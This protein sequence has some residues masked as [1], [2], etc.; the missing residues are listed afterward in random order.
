[1]RAHGRDIIEIFGYAPDDYSDESAKW[2]TTEECPFVGGLCTKRSHENIVYG[3]CSLSA[4]VSNGEVIVCPK[5]LYAENYK[6]LREVVKHAWPHSSVRLFF[7]ND[8]LSHR[9][10]EIDR[11]AVAYGQGETSELS[12]NLGDNRLSMDWVIQSYVRQGNRFIPDTFVGVEI[13]S[14][15]ITGN[16]KDCWATYKK[17]RLKSNRDRCEAVPSS[18]HGLNWANVHK[19]LIPQ[20]IRKGN[21]YRLM[22]RC[23]GF[24]FILPSAVYNK[25]DALLVNLDNVSNSANDVLTVMT[26]SLGAKV[27]HGM[28]R[29]LVSDSVK[30]YRLQ[31]FIQ[32]FSSSG[33][34][35]SAAKELDERL[36]RL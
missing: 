27:E 29:S 13:Q 4:G 33:D 20:I 35:F 31:D 10:N 21:V 5:R 19:R 1:M 7:C 26:Y 2:W 8:N 18:M 11:Y 3:V 24:Y 32:A 12:T 28:I 15:D 22:E 34:Y 6:V 14:I 23:I 9:L 30:N 25:F 16:Y 36:L 17:N